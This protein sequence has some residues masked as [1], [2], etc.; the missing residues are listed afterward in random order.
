MIKIVIADDHPVVSNGLKSLIE[1]DL[2]M[3]VIGLAE[4]STDLFD[5]LKEKKCD[6]IVVDYS[7]PGSQKLPDGMEMLRQL[8]M[9]HSDK[10]LILFTMMDNPGIL[11]SLVKLGISIIVS[12]KDSLEYLHAAILRAVNNQS[13]FSPSI[14]Q[15]FN[16]KSKGGEA[17][18]IKLS[19]RELEVLRLCA[20]GLTLVSIARH[21]NR[22]DRTIS[23][24]KSI[25]MRK[26]GLRNDY[27][28]YQYA[29]STGLI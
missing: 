9:K 24:Q 21:L 19:K 10:T 22:S 18:G 27:E 15:I 11:A 12:K 29:I 17:K 8:R 23:S 26:L 1:Q 28:L 2:Q 20:Q 25:A 16:A 6:V 7:M 14:S 3:K 5:L 13:F 4:S